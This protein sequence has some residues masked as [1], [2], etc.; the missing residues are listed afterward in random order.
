MSDG[1]TDMNRRML[2]DDAALRAFREPL[3]GMQVGDPQ[4]SRVRKAVDAAVRTLLDEESTDASAPVAGAA[5][6]Q[7][8]Q[9]D[10]DC[11]RCWL[12]WWPPRPARHRTRRHCEPVV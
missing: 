3:T 11:G 9:A 2:A 7:E 6:G 4:E 12:R 1:I 8:T 10:M 5:G